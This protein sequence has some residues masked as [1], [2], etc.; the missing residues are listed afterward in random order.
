MLK[1]GQKRPSRPQERAQMDQNVPTPLVLLLH[2]LDALLRT[3]DA[4]LATWC[5]TLRIFMHFMR[6]T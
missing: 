5:I 1:G 6:F 3:L 4:L 2:T